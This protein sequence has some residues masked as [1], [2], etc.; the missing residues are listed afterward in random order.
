MVQLNAGDVRIFPISNRKVNT[1]NNFATEY[2]IASIINQLTG[3]GGFVITET[4][5][6]NKEFSFNIAGYCF[7]IKAGALDVVLKDI[8]SGATNLYA[9]INFSNVSTEGNEI[10]IDYR[11]IDGEDNAAGITNFV[12]FTT[13]W[14]E[15]S[16]GGGVLILLSRTKLSE[17]P[18]YS[19]WQIPDTSRIKFIPHQ[20]FNVDNGRISKNF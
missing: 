9:Y 12:Q 18:T 13:E 20:N 7:T 6:V 4:F 10:D 15:A 19:N 17:T 16:Q 5:D 3:S 14:Q 8:P 1:G 11:K 2:N